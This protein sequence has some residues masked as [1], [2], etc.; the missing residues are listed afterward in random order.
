MPA[1]H[2][3]EPGLAG[4]MGH[5]A[6]HRPYYSV[7]ADGVH[8]HA[9][10]LRM[11]LRTDP[12]RC[13]LITDSVELAGLPDGLYPGNGQIRGRQRKVGARVTL[14]REEEK[15]VEKANGEGGNAE[16][17]TL[18]G[19]CCS[20]DQCVRNM[21]A[22]THCTLAEAVRCVTE[23]VA[24]LMGEAERG[25]L[26]AGRRADLV[27][28]DLDDDDDDGAGFTVRETWLAGLKVYSR[29]REEE[30]GAG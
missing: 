12:A 21:V 6:P 7:I 29:E 25:V 24:G 22:M 13:I 2:H 19:S 23:N 1:L 11:A 26:E 27:V 17:E 10:V 5:A 28:L 30:Q 14:V 3:R 9:S 15:D 4:L 8:L 16:E 18:I 20:L